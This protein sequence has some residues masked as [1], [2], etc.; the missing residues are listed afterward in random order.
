MRPAQFVV[1]AS[2]SAA[3]FRFR[4]FAPPIGVVLSR[5]A[6]DAVRQSR[7]REAC[8]ITRRSS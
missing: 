4:S 2:V 8:E 5:G 7:N 1:A 3:Q 6:I